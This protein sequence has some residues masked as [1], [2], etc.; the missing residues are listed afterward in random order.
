MIFH[1]NIL[2]NGLKDLSDRF[3]SILAAA[4]P[5]TCEDEGH[6]SAIL[7]NFSLI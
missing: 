3:R 1:C 7:S 6:V 5:V 2:K 4:N